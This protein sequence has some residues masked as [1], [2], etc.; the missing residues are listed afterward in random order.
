MIC[1]PASCQLRHNRCIFLN[2]FDRNQ[3]VKVGTMSEVIQTMIRLKSISLYSEVS[4]K[5]T[6]NG[7]TRQI[8][9]EI[10]AVYAL[11]N[12]QFLRSRKMLQRSLEIVVGS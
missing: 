7:E 9:S 6:F 11:T 5:Q 10:I 12:K 3:V 2:F 8:M 4:A 1:I